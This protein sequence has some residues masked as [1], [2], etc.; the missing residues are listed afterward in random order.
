MGGVLA[1]AAYK[2]AIRVAAAVLRDSQG[3]VLVCQRPA[4][5]TLA[6]LW[7]FPGGKLEPG[8][9]AEAALRRELF[10]ELGIEVRSCRPLMQLQH[11]YPE[12]HVE[13]LVWLIEHYDGEARGL[14]GQ[15]LRWVHVQELPALDLLPADLPIIDYLVRN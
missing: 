15:A 13:L 8:E 12:R 10:E 9:A 3:R 11:E 7:E 1:E 4:G 14:E 6:G 5:K 2:A